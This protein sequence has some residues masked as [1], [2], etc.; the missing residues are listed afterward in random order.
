MFWR[1][2][3]TQLF[4]IFRQNTEHAGIGAGHE[5]RVF[6]RR[7][8]RAILARCL[9]IVHGGCFCIEAS[10]L[11]YYVRLIATREIGKERLGVFRG[12][13]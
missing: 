4:R 1:P 2:E 11:L 3:A 8:R 13:S 6:V 7:G 5:F 9:R 10:R 12:Q